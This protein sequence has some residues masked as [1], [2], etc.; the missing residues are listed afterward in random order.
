MMMMKGRLLWLAGVVVGCVVVGVSGQCD[1][2]P[3]T[4]FFGQASAVYD[5]NDGNDMCELTTEIRGE[6]FSQMITIDQLIIN[7]APCTSEQNEYTVETSEQCTTVFCESTQVL[8]NTSGAGEFQFAFFQGFSVTCGERF[9]ASLAVIIGTPCEDFTLA[10]FTVSADV[11][12]AIVQ[13]GVATGSICIPNNEVEVFPETSAMSLV[14]NYETVAAVP[15]N[16][17]PDVSISAS[18]ETLVSGFG[19]TVL[20]EGMFPLSAMSPCSSGENWDMFSNGRLY[21]PPSDEIQAAMFTLFQQNLFASNF[22]LGLFATYNVSVPSQF[23]SWVV[24]GDTWKDNCASNFQY[25]NGA[26]GMAIAVTADLNLFDILP[27]EADYT[28]VFF[29]PAGGAIGSNEAPQCVY[30]KSFGATPTPTPTATATPTQTATATPTPTPMPTPVCVDAEWVSANHAGFEVHD[31][32]TFAEVLCYGSVLPCA[33]QGHVVAR[34]GAL[35]TMMELCAGD[36]VEC[37]KK[38]MYVNGVQHERHGLMPCDGDVCMTTLDAR[39]NS[40]WKR[41]ENGIVYRLLQTGVTSVAKRLTQ[42]QL[43]SAAM[44]A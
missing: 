38:A 22:S 18:H 1:D 44:H 30:R 20:T 36:G 5:Q 26:I 39:V 23:F 32:A 28:Y 24:S 17:C 13:D 37:T 7:G 43:R 19:N 34:N 41:V 4:N 2:S 25:G 29:Q 15:V 40:A 3:Q 31:K 14:G 12:V 8:L 42:I 35:M 21:Q 27:L 10:G 11:P 33:T 9:F 6:V 16:A